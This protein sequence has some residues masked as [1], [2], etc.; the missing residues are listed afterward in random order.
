MNMIEEDDY[1]DNNISNL[2]CCEND[3]NEDD[4]KEEYFD[5]HI[6]DFDKLMIAS[7]K[8][9]AASNGY[10]DECHQGD[11]GYYSGYSMINL[12]IG[13]PSVKLQFYHSTA[14]EAVYSVANETEYVSDFSS[15]L[16]E[17]ILYKMMILYLHLR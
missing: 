8:S 13:T 1:P 5:L 3:T 16:Y 4:N 9:T 15:L 14:S 10:Q 7:S 11:D 2:L 6:P 17:M 12:S